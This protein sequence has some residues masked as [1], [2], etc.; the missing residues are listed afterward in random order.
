MAA[1]P[2]TFC[3][4]VV[5]YDSLY[6]LSCANM[7]TVVTGIR[8]CLVGLLVRTLLTRG[9]QRSKLEGTFLLS[10]LVAACAA[11]G[12]VF[13]CFAFPSLIH[14]ETFS[15]N[16]NNDMMMLQNEQQC[17]LGEIGEALPPAGRRTICLALI[18]KQ[19]DD[20]FLC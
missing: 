8:G 12:V 15:S 14:A 17:K 13:V 6:E 9:Q 19:M 5:T 20:A 2:S 4:S 10:W 1:Q 7:R 11:A 16:N 3:T 18:S